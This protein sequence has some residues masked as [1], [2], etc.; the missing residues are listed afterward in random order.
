MPEKNDLNGM[1]VSF[2]LSIKFLIQLL[3]INLK[4][5]TMKWI[6]KVFFG[7]GKECT[8][9]GKTK[10]LLSSYGCKKGGKHNWK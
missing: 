8:K 5:N 6:M 10:G 4:H 1:N 2:V 7:F 9:C 3:C